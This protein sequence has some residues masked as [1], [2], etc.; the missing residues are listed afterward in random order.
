[1]DRSDVS[2]ATIFI[3]AVFML[4]PLALGGWLALIPQVKADLGLT[5]SQLAIALMG[6][7]LAVVPGLQIAGRVISRFGPRRISAAFFPLQSLVFVLPL[8]AWSGTS[9][10]FVLFFA[11]L[12]MAFIEVAMNVYAG[13]LEKQTT[14]LIMNRCH[15]FWAFG[16]MLGSASM[17]MTGQGITT[18]VALAVISAVG[19]VLASRALVKLPGEDT[20]VVP[21]RRALSKLPPALLLIAVFMFVITLV[22]GVMADWAAVYLSERLNDPTARAGI[23]VTI[24]SAFLAGGR[25]LGDILKGRFG[26][27]RHAQITL[28]CVVA[29]LLSLIFPLPLWVAYF[30]FAFV[31]FGVSAAYPLG[32]SA[33][34][35]LDDRY[36]APNIA[37]AATVAM[38]G[39]MIGPPL[40][41]FLGQAFSL[42]VAFAAL[43]PGVFLAFWLTRW[44]RAEKGD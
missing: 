27:V 35:A 14:A 44:L 16:L 18:Q 30:G 37:I 28:V 8:L 15:G 29:G 32:V 40:I 33:V 11:G 38:G 9:L 12:M 36:E 10:F 22:E 31:G 20:D 39:F 25:F 21:P 42:A 24:F 17:A 19:G 3:M 2:R 13:R 1:M 7:P 43:L 34:A 4:Q 26:A 6:I 41:G 5:K 23:A